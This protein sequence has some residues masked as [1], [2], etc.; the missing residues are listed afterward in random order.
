M[1]LKKLCRKRLFSVKQKVIQL[2]ILFTKESNS[3]NL[4]IDAWKIKT[5]Y[6]Q[7][8]L[9]DLNLK[10]IFT[11]QGCFVLQWDKRLSVFLVDQYFINNVKG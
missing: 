2:A 1:F 8:V 7:L 3:S 5:P 9:L 6:T 10:D 11:K 4:Q